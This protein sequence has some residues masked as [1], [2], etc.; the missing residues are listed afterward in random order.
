MTI[1]KVG[2]VARAGSPNYSEAEAGGGRYRLS[3]GVED[4]SKVDGN[5]SRHGDTK[6]TIRSRDNT[7]HTSLDH[8]AS[9][10]FN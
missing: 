10:F 4:H 6:R 5:R 1:L 3:S 9:S 7:L 8:K 2:V